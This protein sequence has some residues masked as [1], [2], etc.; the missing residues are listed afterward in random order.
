MQNENRSR[1]QASSWFAVVRAYQECNRRYSQVLAAFDLTVPQFD[2]MMA[3]LALD[4][5]ATP[6]AIA[7]RLVVT[8]GN[9]TGVLHR[10]QARALIATERHD[11][12][13]RSFVCRLTEEGRAL[14]AVARHAASLFIERQLAP[15]DAAELRA[16][17]RTMIQMRAHLQTIDPEEIVANVLTESPGGKREK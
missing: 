17:E 3:I 7:E 8:R 10:L 16:T 4:R 6:K 14:L 9:I 11:Q 5:G 1:L 13:R 15:F 2:V 12:D